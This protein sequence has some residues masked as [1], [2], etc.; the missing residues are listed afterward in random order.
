MN[1]TFP[2]FCSRITN[3]N[4]KTILRRSR[5][6]T[7]NALRGDLAVDSAPSDVFS[8][9]LEFSTL[10][11]ASLRDALVSFLLS[12]LIQVVEMVERAHKTSFDGTSFQTFRQFFDD[13][14]FFSNTRI[15]LS[16]CAKRHNTRHCVAA[17][18][19]DL[20]RAM[21]NLCCDNPLVVDRVRR[22][23]VWWFGGLFVSRSTSGL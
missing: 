4:E 15:Q 18:K 6:Q 13:A 20:L 1:R 7:K 5:K 9:Q 3:A 2:Q 17:V 8:T 22:F 23:S 16:A 10:C 12:D 14:I 11:A 21:A 19:R